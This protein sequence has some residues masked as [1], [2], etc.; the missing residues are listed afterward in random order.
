MIQLIDEILD[1]PEHKWVERPKRKVAAE[2]ARK[3][4]VQ[5]PLQGKQPEP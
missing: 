4:L 1:R 3:S 5:Q 2:E